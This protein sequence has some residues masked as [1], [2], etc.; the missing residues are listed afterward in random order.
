MNAAP[1]PD[2]PPVTTTAAIL[3]FEKALMVSFVDRFLGNNL[4][5]NRSESVP[6]RRV[7]QTKITY[8]AYE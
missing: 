5:S 4:P 1:I 3:C 6:L 7:K 8:H 2:E